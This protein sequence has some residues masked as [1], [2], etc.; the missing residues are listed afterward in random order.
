[1]IFYNSI[2]LVL[3]L[4]FTFSLKTSAQIDKL[5]TESYTIDSIIHN[6]IHYCKTRKLDTFVTIGKNYYTNF[7]YKK[8][9]QSIKYRFNWNISDNEQSVECFVF[10]GELKKVTVS[11]I[12]YTDFKDQYYFKNNEIVTHRFS[13]ICR[14]YLSNEL[15]EFKQN[16]LIKYKF[17]IKKIYEEKD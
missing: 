5:R 7:T 4:S 1:M 11:S 6:Q 9:K 2:Y 17:I 3:L 15:E 14:L 13:P 10:N 8:N 16:E 12:E